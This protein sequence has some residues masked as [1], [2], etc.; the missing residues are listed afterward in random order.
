M[1]FFV[2]LW[3]SPLNKV[4]DVFFLRVFFIFMVNTVIQSEIQWHENKHLFWTQI[5]RTEMTK[6][7]T[8]T[9]T[10]PEHFRSNEC[11]TEKKY[12]TFIY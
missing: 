8:R 10:H 5:S 4:F 6:S 12:Q 2:L 3:T 11:G 1:L 7:V 9:I